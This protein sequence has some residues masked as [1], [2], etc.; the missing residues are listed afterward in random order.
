MIALRRRKRRSGDSTNQPAT[1]AGRRAKRLANWSVNLLVTGLVVV[2]GLTFGRQA[3]YWWGADPSDVDDGAIQQEVAPTS[4][5]KDGA[6]QLLSFGDLPFG[7][8]QRRLRGDRDHAFAQLR[9][10]CSVSARDGVLL[11]GEV[12][13]AERKMLQRLPKM[14]PVGGEPGKW[15][16]YQLDGPLLMVAIVKPPPA[17]TGRV[18]A[19]A[20]RV[21]SWGLGVPCGDEEWTLFVSAADQK[22]AAKHAETTSLPIPPR[23][24]RSMSL[25]TEDGT[26]LIGLVGSGQINDWREFYTDW[27]DGHNWSM[28]AAWR[29]DS[30]QWLGR[31][32]NR[33]D[34]VRIQISIQHDYLAGM[35]TVTPRSNE[36]ED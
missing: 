18:A 1:E 19:G 31:F 3:M 27:F 26:A 5:G 11:T 23:S 15:A 12:G 32:S 9:E 21:V 4:F 22:P 13:T 7:F 34:R 16:M 29:Q 36:V 33:K 25:R 6:T 20:P 10:I 35:I 17:D 14:K 28:D 2:V 30:G 8:V 24:R